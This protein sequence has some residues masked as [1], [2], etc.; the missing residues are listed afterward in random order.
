MDNRAEP[1]GSGSAPGEPTARYANSPL[2][3]TEAG[4]ALAS[5][6]RI[7]RL[8]ARALRL[9]CPNCGRGRVM[10]SWF[11]VRPSCSSCGIRFER[12]EHDY[13]LGAMLFNLV[14]AELL[15]AAILVVV[16]VAMWPVVPWDFLQ[17]GGVALMILLPFLLFP[18]S[19]T[20]WMAF[21]LMLRPP[22]A[23]EFELRPGVTGPSGA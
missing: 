19:R 12:G 22:T 3:P 5:P 1:N 2:N 20:I 10:A 18:V 17:Y 9:R 15:F 11:G 8:F 4:L 7:L 23:D 13:F 16:L 21:D 6:K 14:L